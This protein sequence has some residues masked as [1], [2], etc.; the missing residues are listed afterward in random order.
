M[1]AI[2][3]RRRTWGRGWP[4]GLGAVL[5]LSAIGWAAGFLWFVAAVP[6]TV[7]DPTRETDAIVVL[8]GGS[9]RVNQG[10][11]LLNAERAEHLFV[12]GVY[13]GVDVDE[14]LAAQTEPSKGATCCVSLGYEA[15]T[16][17]GNAR[18]TAAWIT[19]KDISS[20]RLVTAAYHMPRSLLEFRRIM[21]GITIVPHP[22][23]P[24][25]VKHDAWWRWPGSAALLAREYNKMLV[26]LLRG[27]LPAEPA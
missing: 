2:G 13:E 16:T 10:L 17:R 22:V 18:E 5:G 12:S 24:D 4:R 8:T 26:T 3:A 14:L 9:G 1:A 19:D 25:H 6:D 21:P 15:Q 11:R 7:P 20:L 27:M 23:F